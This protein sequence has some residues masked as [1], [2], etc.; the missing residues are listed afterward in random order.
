MFICYASSSMIPL[1][2]IDV[3]KN[4]GSALFVDYYPNVASLV[5]TVCWF[6]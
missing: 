6:Y 1:Q 2:Q 4:C 3:I 5:T